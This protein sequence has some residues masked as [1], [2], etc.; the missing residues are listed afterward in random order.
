MAAEVL[1]MPSTMRTISRCAWAPRR[2]TLA[3]SAE[4]ALTWL[5]REASR[6]WT[7]STSNGTTRTSDTITSR[8][9]TPK[10]ALNFGK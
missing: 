1:S 9:R 2:A 5:S 10:I 6:I 3:S 4:A 7:L 8:A